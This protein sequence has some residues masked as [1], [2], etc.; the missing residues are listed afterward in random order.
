MPHAWCSHANVSA[1]K[2]AWRASSCAMAH[3][4]LARAGRCAAGSSAAAAFPNSFRAARPSPSRP[5]R[6]AALCSAEWSRRKATVC[7]GN[8]SAIPSCFSFLALLSARVMCACIASSSCARIACLVRCGGAP[9][10]NSSRQSFAK[11]PIE[12]CSAR[13]SPCHS[14]RSAGSMLATSALAPPKSV[15]S[16]GSNSSVPLTSS[17]FAA[18]S[19]PAPRKAS[20]TSRAAKSLLGACTAHFSC[21]PKLLLAE[22][23]A[24]HAARVVVVLRSTSAAVQVATRVWP[25]VMYGRPGTIGPVLFN[26]SRYWYKTYPHARMLAATRT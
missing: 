13:P 21:K 19:V 3:R 10:T 9:A 23:H 26:E 7:S 2:A 17:A 18:A 16:S 6:A 12:A 20:S 1:A 5:S 25:A 14:S 4:S 15:A 24:L 22:P 11:V 8:S